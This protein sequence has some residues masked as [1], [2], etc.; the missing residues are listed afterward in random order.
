MQTTL[1][2]TLR[3]LKKSPG[4]VLTAIATFAIG[5]GTNATV[6]GVLNA[7]LFQPAAGRHGAALYMIESGSHSSMQGFQ[8]Y[9]DYLD[10]RDRTQS[11]SG[12]AAYYIM[13]PAGFDT[14]HDPT[15]VWPLETSNNYFDALGVQPYI[16]Q[17]FHGSNDRAIGSAPYVVLSYAFWHS[18]F[19]DDRNVV[20]R[21]VE[22]NKHPFTILGVAPAEFRGTELFFSPDLWVPI[23]E[24]P[25]IEA[26]TGLEQRSS[27]YIEIAGMLKPGVSASQAQADLNGAAANLAKSYPRDDEGISF[28]LS[29]PGLLGNL[30]GAPARAYVSSLMLLT[31]LILLAACANIGILFAARTTDR[32]REIALRVALGSHHGSIVRQMMAESVMVS[33]IGGGVGS[34]GAMA[35]LHWLATRNPVPEMPV[36]VPVYPGVL[37]YLLALLVTLATGILTGLV[38]LRQVLQIDPWQVVREGE[39]SLIGSRRFSL[40]DLLLM[41]QI[42]V[43]TV[44]VASCLVAIRGLMRSL[45]SNFGFAPHQVLLVDSHLRMAGYD[46]AR[47]AAMQRRMQDAIARVPGVSAVAY[48]D[49]LPLT[50]NW[51]PVT[52]FRDETVDY[53]QSNRAADAEEYDVSPEYLRVAGASLLAGRSFTLEDTK[54]APLVAVVNLEFAR[55]VFGSVDKAIGAHFKMDSGVRLQVV[56]IAEDGKYRTITEDPRPAIFCPILQQPSSDTVLLVRSDR[57]ERDIA[58]ALQ[59]TVSALDPAL[60]FRITS[61]DAELDWPLF[62]TRSAAIALSVLGALGAML[63]ITG[64]FGTASYAVSKRLRDLAIRVAL[65]ANRREV[66]SA[67]LGRA[68]VLLAIGSGAGIGLALTAAHVLSYIVYQA[69]PADPVVVCGVAVTMLA[70]GLAS[71]WFP[72]RRT[73]AIDPVIFLKDR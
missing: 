17:F 60:P 28:S 41:L 53:R 22:V 19:H 62:A 50:L 23:V 56:G 21:S 15:T 59:Q 20:G 63:A 52:I 42:V 71:T 40:R 16:G 6:F 48:T 45:H 51:G 47:A 61:W 1:K 68:F 33:L 69:T 38:P 36:H 25:T 66:L 24:Q 2:Y 58:A 27:R 11:F 44:L 8:S 72:A 13:G 55:K 34:L 70:L 57:S 18:R 65:G 31:I 10:L 49:R 12:L 32:S 39:G 29:R 9:L 7:L 14:G 43:C 64:V 35:L 3:Q 5:I 37:T 4:F 46:G 30:L 73:L 54:N 26:W 67:A